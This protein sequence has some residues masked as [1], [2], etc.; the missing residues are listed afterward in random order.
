VPSSHDKIFEAHHFIH[1]FILSYH[2]PNEF[3][4]N[5]SAFF[6]SARSTTLMIQSEL[7]HR[8]GFEAWWETQRAL[9]ASDADLK[10][11]NDFRVTAFH[12]SSLVPGSRI[13]A[14]H[15]KYARPKSGLV[16]DISPF[17]PTLPAFLHSRKIM[18]DREHPHRM[19]ENEEFGMQRTWRLKEIGDRELVRFCDECWKKLVEVLSETHGWLGQA[20]RIENNCKHLGRDFQTLLESEIFAEVPKAW[21]SA[22][23]ELVEPAVETLQLYAEPNEAAEIYYSVKKGQKIKGWIGGRSPLW[24]SNFASM[25]VYSMDD[26]VVLR[27]TSVFI[28]LAD[29]RVT[30]LVGEEVD[31]D[32]EGEK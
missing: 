11:L 29:S 9:M 30:P 1:Q 32:D 28:K 16:M 13:F 2:D 19:W 12:K 20:F 27:N 21:D 17:T 8:P 14:G 5:L 26:E 31:A 3:R 7:A 18:A 15:F 25:L 10:L 23:T 24:S 22:P 6:Q 4:F